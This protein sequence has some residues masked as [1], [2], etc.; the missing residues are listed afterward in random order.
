MPSSRFACSVAAVFAFV[1]PLAAQSVTLTPDNGS[2]TALTGTIGQPASFTIR[3]NGGTGNTTYYL[4]CY[5]SGAVTSCAPNQSTITIPP[6]FNIPVGA[7]YATGAV[8]NGV[9]QLKAC[10]N[11][12][13]SQAFD[14]GTYNVTVVPYGVAVAAL[15]DTAP[16][17]ATY[18]GGFTTQFTVTNK[19][20]ATESLTLTCQ[21]VTNATSC[22]SV[23][24]SSL[25]N[26]AAS[27]SAMVTVTYSALGPGWGWVQL[28]ASGG[29]ASASDLTGVQVVP[30][31]VAVTPD[32][33]SV[34]TPVSTNR[35]QL[36]TIQNVTSSA[37]TY[38]F[39][40]LCTGTG[41]SNCSQPA[42]QSV[43]AGSSATASVSYTS[44]AT[45]GATG[46]IRLQASG[47]PGQ[48]SG[49]VNVTLASMMSPDTVDVTKTTAGSLAEPN[50]C[51]TI[52][53]S[54]GAAY[55]CG[56][57]RIVHALP[58]TRTMSRVRT[59]TLLYSSQHAHP[60]PLVGANL[61]LNSA[62][63]TPDSVVATLL[64]NGIIHGRSR[65]NGAD[66]IPGRANRV[67][68]AD[69]LL[70]RTAPHMDTVYS[71][72][73]EAVNYY[74]VTPTVAKT[75][76]GT[77]AVVDRSASPFGAGWWLAGLEHLDV[78]TKI[79]T[80]GDG[81]LRQYTS[82]GANVWAA[83][84]L[85]RP[86]TLKWDGT[87]YLR[88]LAHGD[89]VKFDGQGL[90]VATVNRLGQQT[91]FAYDGC[92]RLQSITL[93]P[94]GSG[95]VYQLAY[96]S[97]TDCAT[98]LQ[99]V[100]APA[101]GGT[102]RVTTLTVVNR[103]VTAIRDPDNTTVNFAYG[104]G[105]DTNRIASRT[106][107][108]GTVTTFTYDGGKKIARASIANGTGQPAI[109]TRFRA[110]QS[111]GLPGAGTPSAPDTAVVYTRLD[112]PRLDV[113]DT[114]VF[115]ENRFSTPYRVMNALGAQTKLYYD[116]TSWPALVTHLAYVNGRALGAVYDDR[117]N[118]LS[119]TDSSVFQN[120]KYAT[121][122]FVWNRKW[123]FDSIVARPEGDSIVISYDP[124]NGNRVW[125]QD[126][127]GAS[128]KTDFYYYSG[129]DSVRGLLRSLRTPLQSVSGPRDSVTYNALGNLAGTKTP[130]GFWTL[131]RKDNVGRDTLIIVPLLDTLKSQQRLTY[132]VSDRVTQSRSTGPQLKYHDAIANADSLTKPESLWVATF[133]NAEGLPDSL[134]RWARPNWNAVNTLTTKWTYDP[135]GRRLKETAPD[136]AADSTVY[137]RAAN[138]VKVVTR[139]GH[140]I[141]LSHDILNRLVQRVTPAVTYQPW[142]PNAQNEIW[143]FPL[144]CADGSGGLTVGNTN[145]T[146]TLTIG[147]ETETF[148][149][150]VVGD[151]LTA[152]NL[153]TRIRRGYNL[154]GSI[155]GDTLIILPYVG[156]D[157]TLH[158]YG[159]TFTYDLD[160]RRTSVRHPYPIAPG[161]AQG[162]VKDLEQYQYYSTT[163]LLQS[164]AD[165]FGIGYEYTY[166]LENRVSQ[167]DRGESVLGGSPQVRATYGYDVD[168]RD[169][170]RMETFVTQ[171]NAVLHADTLF[172]DARSKVV[173]A[174][175]SADTTNL[176]YTGL[177]ALAWSS[178]F[179]RQS[180]YPQLRP[181]ERHLPDALG[182]LYE[183]TR[184]ENTGS[185]IDVTGL[186]YQA[187]TG[188]LLNTWHGTA[189]NSPHSAEANKT[190]DA[191]GNIY[192]AD[193]WDNRSAQQLVERTAS[194]YD[195]AGRLRVQDHRSCLMLTQT[196]ICDQINRPEYNDRAAF[197]EYRYDAL[198]RRVLVR[199]RSE[200]YCAL[201][202]RNAI[203]R[204]VW[205]GDQILYEISSQGGTSATTAQLEQDTAQ[206][207]QQENGNYEPYG[208][209]IY[210]HGAG[211]DAPLGV[212]RMNFSDVFPEATLVLPLANWQ[213]EYDL[214]IIAG[215]KS[216]ISQFGRHYPG[217]TDSVYYFEIDWPA[218]YMWKTLYSRSRGVQGPR[219]WMGSLIE[220]GRDASGQMYRRNR[221]Y[222]PAIGRFTQEDPI[223]LAGG[224]NLYGFAGGDPVNF[225]D[226]FGLCVDENGNWRRCVVR[227]DEQ[228]S[229]T[230]ISARTKLTIQD[231]ADAA[232]V[233]LT[234]SS[235]FRD[236]TSCVRTLHAC[237]TAV[238]INRINGTRVDEASSDLVERVQSA[239]RGFSD[240]QENLGPQ[241]LFGS[242]RAG[243]PQY[244]F[245]NEELQNRHLNHIH[246]GF[247]RSLGSNRWVDPFAK[248]L[249]NF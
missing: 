102:A 6:N 153:A 69:T 63:A 3:K 154:N 145:G 180:E 61:S 135:A 34:G 173:R 215:Y 92:S 72:T 243:E 150:D 85:A 138:P 94:T 86:D 165:G 87:Y 91:V 93:P 224:L 221:Y 249:V 181:S 167:L 78:V 42:S 40:V 213:G 217:P 189:R 176:T 18:S 53:A 129:A 103:R 1:S 128:S 202:C 246:I 182:N 89:T 199:T 210:T 48:D 68:V 186:T 183:S 233:D 121:T 152:N 248:A 60:Y 159:L 137:D 117:G 55:Q 12:Q 101:I 168:G 100:T 113:G 125:Q 105:A 216:P 219:S 195:A 44:S 75:T 214:G 110:V 45:L 122:R 160:G 169:S 146:C 231:L 229:N 79:W 26:L 207:V 147:A 244:M 19:T 52:A 123:D 62:A 193:S 9:V 36:F 175:T 80:G 237:G 179:Q 108:R 164:V 172:Y 191:A 148:T 74:G 43:P 227:W 194:Y 203:T 234:L 140:T 201:R 20:T 39:S 136:G 32:E 33:K 13:C 178:S 157:T 11:A 208:R 27:A 142:N 111:Y 29:A 77:F 239:A 83:P 38:T 130:S 192:R 2:L 155:A 156:T 228:A 174:R 161:N 223:G 247:R 196:L 170:L 185:S 109:T 51:V 245:F 31:T 8:G 81:A 222:D 70:V 143:Y 211:V 59:P 119:V 97:P 107:R 238:D 134:Q 131:Y 204:F 82:A 99:T 95:R 71:Y 230:R 66:W 56:D 23:S 116:N 4:F 120:G 57:L 198:G 50:I 35:T 190:Y 84:T 14:Y 10:D 212:V 98:K 149:Y 124:T 127:R 151:L 76:T 132:D 184:R 96:A 197:E 209:V 21:S 25:T 141:T 28:T 241:G 54:R 163:G 47:A 17:Q 236:F 205:D 114:T 126:G 37:V 162:V 15:R 65:L 106:D 73:L 67:V 200:W 177:G 133:Y 225:S 64:V 16:P 240:V 206:L 232:D 115:W 226:P 5:P 166:D 118:L 242:P 104:T 112:G 58:T 22:A 171:A 90:H 218:P 220:A 88:I 144:F 24:P 188:R 187:T 235:G 41:V 46:R 158:V 30:Y 7:T 139:R 49:W